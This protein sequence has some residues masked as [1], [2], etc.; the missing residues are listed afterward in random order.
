MPRQTPL[1]IGGA[2]V[3]TAIRQGRSG[4][5]Q[6]YLPQAAVH[7]MGLAAGDQVVVTGLAEGQL[8]MKKVVAQQPV[9]PRAARATRA[10]P[11]TPPATGLDAE[12]RRRR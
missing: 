5:V 8:M 6:F 7:F 9:T 4:R 10:T 11:A 1:G 2:L 12:F 3:G